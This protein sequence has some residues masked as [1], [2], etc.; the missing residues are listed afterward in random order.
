MIICTSIFGLGILYYS[1]HWKS[2][3]IRNFVMV[4]KRVSNQTTSDQSIK[5]DSHKLLMWIAA[6]DATEDRDQYIIHHLYMAQDICESSTTGIFI[7][8]FV[9][10]AANNW[11]TV[12]PLCEFRKKHADRINNATNEYSPNDFTLIEHFNWSC[13]EFM[14]AY[15]K[16]DLQLALPFEH[17]KYFQQYIDV[18]DWFWYTEEDILYNIDTYW[19]LIEDTSFA[20]RKLS[21]EDT[22][23][24]LKL[25]ANNSKRPELSPSNRY[26]F[27]PTALRFEKPPNHGNDITKNSADWL[28]LWRLPDLALAVQPMIEALIFF[29]EQWWIQP[30]SSHTGYYLLPREHLDMIIKQNRWL[31][32]SNV[33]Y[34]ELISSFWLLD[35]GYIRITSITKYKQYLVH[36]GSNRYY[37]DHGNLPKVSTFTRELGFERKGNYFLPTKQMI[38]AQ[39]LEYTIDHQYDIASCFPLSFSPILGRLHDGTAVC[40]KLSSMNRT[41]LTIN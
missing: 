38:D 19:T 4:A 8:L 11:N 9:A 7:R 1:R 13:V 28:D 24:L 18:F 21:S 35:Y 29:K 5:R 6:Y 27:L 3:H 39:L 31:N 10:S 15:Y 22:D 30:S 20:L 34:R 12:E 17:R 32:E 40:T 23:D 37:D 14:I 41:N 16:D 25:Y 2:D 26:F 33:K 36:H